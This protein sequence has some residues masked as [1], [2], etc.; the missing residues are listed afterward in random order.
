MGI[1]WPQTSTASSLRPISSSASRSAVSSMCASLSSWKPPGKLQQS[2][3][4]L[5][6]QGNSSVFE[7][8]YACVRNE[9]RYVQEQV[10]YIQSLKGVCA[11]A[12]T[13]YMHPAICALTFN[14][15]N[16]YH[17]RAHAECAL[18]QNIH[19]LTGTLHTYLT[20]P[21]CSFSFFERTVY[22]SDGTPAIVQSGIKIAA[23]LK[24]FLSE[25]D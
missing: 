5:Y 25:S 12:R 20:W 9:I 21:P 11:T 13:V 19:D 17:G 2:A 14:K 1:I 18:V 22:S 10:K 16:I 4:T 23:F 3:T 6:V 8:K 7:Q 24:S 15:L